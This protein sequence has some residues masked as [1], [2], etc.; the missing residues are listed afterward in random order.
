VSN[1]LPKADVVIIGLGAVGGIVAHVLTQAGINVVGL[2]AGPRLDLTTFLAND[3][4][5]SGVIRFW[6]GKPKYLHELPTWRSDASSPTRPLPFPPISMA[7]MVGGTSVH[8]GAQSWRYLEDD[9]TTRTSTIT[10][11]GEKVIPP[12]ST[13]TDWPITYGELEPYYDQLEYLIGVSGQ[14]GN[15]NGKLID[16]GNP[17]EAS[18]SREFPM[19]PM[20]SFGFGELARKAMLGL[21][22][23][24]FPQP[25]AIATVPYN[26]RPPCT[27]CGYCQGFGC[28]ND[29]K[30]STLVTA[31]RSAEATGRLEVRPHS[32]VMRI[33]SNDRGQVT[34][35]EYLDESGELQVQPAGVV[36]LS[37][38]IYENVRLLLLSRSDSYADGL[39]NNHGQVGKN[40]MSQTYAV[41]A[42]LFPGKRLNTFSGAGGQAI[43]MDDFNGDNFDHT[44]LDF[45]RGAVI[46]AGIL[47]LPIGM[48]RNVAPGVPQW[49]AAY[50]R[51]MHENADSVGTVYA[52]V[53]PLPYEGVFLDLDPQATDP[54]GD[55]VVRDTYELHENEINPAR[56]M[57]HK[58]AELLNAMGATET[59]STFP[60]GTPL[61]VNT[62]AYGGTR[63]GDDPS[64]SVVTKYGLS[65]EAPNLMILGGSTFPGSAGYNPTETLQAHAWYAADYLAQNLNK[66]AV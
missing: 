11:Y 7:N 26:G 27:Y 50:K 29:S 15:I 65:H 18:R 57:D 43:A 54:L 38:Y 39:A 34:G 53:E 63:M 62:H 22:Y 23:H 5:I 48:S 1:Q 9:F 25:A 47:N 16:G 12:T 37:C 42:G 40:Y 45:I 8:Y 55:P 49:G 33:L 52:Q 6:T 56:F 31:I 58:L 32:R 59:W 41:H 21:G 4:E 66:I 60:V 17:F 44:G 10:R 61:P 24:P 36:I 51:W 14:A 3:D 46:F 35:V 28:W 64:S 2:E 30:S 20:Q 13:L 19:P